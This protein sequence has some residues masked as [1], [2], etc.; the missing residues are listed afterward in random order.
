MKRRTF[1]RFLSE[2]GY[3]VAPVTI[4]NLDVL[5]ALAFDNAHAAADEKL[6]DHIAAAYVEHMRENFAYFESLSRQLFEREPAQVILLHAN[7]LNADH[8][9]EL[10][11]MLRQ[12]GYSFVPLETALRDPAYASLD[13]YVGSPG[14]LWLQRWAI[15]RGLDPGHEPRAPDWVQRIAYPQ[16]TNR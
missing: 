7:A 13:T 3:A 1:E 2:H 8:L 11:A 5:Y 16:Q 12:R 14:P 6:K 4:D 9:L 10:V 15:T